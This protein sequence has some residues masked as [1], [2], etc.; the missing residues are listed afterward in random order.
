MVSVLASNPPHI[1][2]RIIQPFNPALLGTIG[3][4]ESIPLLKELQHLRITKYLKSG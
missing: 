2:A 3:T 4:V 1:L